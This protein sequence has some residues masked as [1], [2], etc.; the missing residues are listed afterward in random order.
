MALSENTNGSQTCTIGTEHTLATVTSAN[1]F[2]LS[3]DLNAMVGGT[4]PDI[5][6]IRE[7][8]KARSSD[9]ERLLKVTT[10]VGAQVEIG[11]QTV[12]RISPHH[13][14]V[15]IKQTQGTGRAVPWSIYQAQ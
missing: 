3:L 14:K 8:M 12:P 13:Y 10:V 6:E 2:Q 1:V 4:T 15:T 9:S 5:L 11:Y 7:Y